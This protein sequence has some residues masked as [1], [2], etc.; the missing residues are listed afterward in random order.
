MNIGPAATVKTFHQKKT[1]ELA[2]LLSDPM[3]GKKIDQ[4]RLFV[5]RYIT[6]FDIAFKDTRPN[7]RERLTLFKQASEKAFELYQAQFN[8]LKKN[9]NQGLAELT[10]LLKDFMRH[11]PEGEKSLIQYQENPKY[12]L[13]QDQLLGA[14][15]NKITVGTGEFTKFPNTPRCVE[16]ELLQ[17]LAK[18]P[19]AFS[20]KADDSNEIIRAT[21]LPYGNFF[22]ELVK[23]TERYTTTP[24]LSLETMTMTLA[25][26]SRFD[27]QSLSEPFLV[28]RVK[29]FKNPTIDPIVTNCVAKL[30]KYVATN[31]TYNTEAIIRTIHSVMLLS[32][33]SDG[34]KTYL[35]DSQAKVLLTAIEDLKLEKDNKSHKKLATQLYQIR[36]I[37]P[38]VFPAKLSDAI[39]PFLASRNED[40]HKSRFED[41]VSDELY[42]ATTELEARYPGLIDR[43][44]F[45]TKNPIC[46]DLGLE[47]DI[48]YENGPVKV[49]IQVDGNKFHQYPGTTS[50]TQRTLLRDFS[51]KSQQWSVAVFADSNKGKEHAIQQ[52][53]RYVVIPTFEMLTNNNIVALHLAKRDLDDVKTQLLQTQFSK[54]KNEVDMLVAQAS[55]NLLPNEILTEINQI[56][57]QLTRI[58]N[59]YEQLVQQLAIMTDQFNQF[60]FKKAQQ[61]T[62]LSQTATTLEATKEKLLNVNSLEMENLT[63]AKTKLNA[64]EKNLEAVVLELAQAE[65]KLNDL[66]EMQNSKEITS[67][68]LEN[69]IKMKL[70]ST[71]IRDEFSKMNK[72]DLVALKIQNQSDLDALQPDLLIKSATHKRL[73][74]EA[75]A[76][77]SKIEHLKTKIATSSSVVDSNDKQ[78]ANIT[79]QFD[80]NEMALK[81]PI[82]GERLLQDLNTFKKYVATWKNGQDSFSQQLTEFSNKLNQLKQAAQQAKPIIWNPKASAFIPQAKQTST[83]PTQ[84]P[85]KTL[86]EIV[87]HQTGITLPQ[88]FSGSH[89]QQRVMVHSMGHYP[90]PVYYPSPVYYTPPVYYPPQDYGPTAAY[91][92][93]PAQC[94]TPM[95]HMHSAEVS[96]ENGCDNQQQPNPQ[97]PSF[98]TAAPG[99]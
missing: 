30:L 64:L 74:T 43:K 97:H 87:P 56:K 32:R 73:T 63:V 16:A 21:Q 18:L 20:A 12:K 77:K 38:A 14:V 52:L 58:E 15:N 76:L 35:T 88:A 94:Y 37:Y 85:E 23:R 75:S 22:K 84:T 79:L 50:T 29:E 54:M 81:S 61:L 96:Q 19:I 10:Q 45:N 41:K 59:V 92:C 1:S 62:T 51:F 44:Y 69:A 17:E 66:T 98:R 72:N 82:M 57:E 46:A 8:A 48:T 80:A 5:K 4:L 7:T 68:N 2:A 26:L 9:K 99:N 24:L 13:F 65:N 39:K 27:I 53:R 47:S 28:Y 95:R 78:L 33:E 42:A 55:N 36:N 40:S 25:A 70:D 86:A 93:E 11:F 89:S 3:L 60:D 91:H 71:Q 49:C 67:T 90:P 6:E 34:F 31:K 83:M